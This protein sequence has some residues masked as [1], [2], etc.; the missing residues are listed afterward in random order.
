M[1]PYAINLIPAA[2]MAAHIALLHASIEAHA[3]DIF[4]EFHSVTVRGH[5]L[6]WS[7]P[8]V[9]LWV[10]FRL[11][12]HHYMVTGNPGWDGPRFQA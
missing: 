1:D 9:H 11:C 8:T 5:R 3:H 6:L 4:S 2:S 10:D 12:Y 7:L